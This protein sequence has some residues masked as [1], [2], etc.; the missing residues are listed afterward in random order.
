MLGGWGWV[1]QLA[2]MFA[3]TAYTIYSEG[4]HFKPGEESCRDNGLMGRMAPRI[5][6]GPREGKYVKQP[7][8]ESRRDNGLTLVSRYV[9]DR[10]MMAYGGPKH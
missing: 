6:I 1:L 5:N 2:C 9:T 10:L 7:G 4:K 3:G 8:E